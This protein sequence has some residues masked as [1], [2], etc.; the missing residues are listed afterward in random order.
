MVGSNLIEHAEAKN[1]QIYAP[2]RK[3]LN[4][5]DY[6]RLLN[7]ME[8]IKP[9]IVIHAAGRVGGIQANI[10]DPAGF[11]T[12]NLKM[13]L[14]V[15]GVSETLG[16]KKLLNLGSSC[17]YS[18]TVKNPIPEDSI[19]KGELEPTNEGYALAKIV[20]ARHCDY[21][22]RNNK[23]KNYKTVIP[24]NLYG[25]YDKYD[26]STSHMI[27]AVIRKIYEAKLTGA[28]I[29]KIWGDGTARREF[30]VASDLA[31]FI[32]FAL[33]RFSELPQYLNVGIGR[34]YSIQEYYT[35]IARVVGFGGSF[36]NDLSKPAGMQQKL[37]DNSLLKNL[38][39][40][41]KMPLQ[42]GL[43]QAFEFYKGTL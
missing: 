23:D 18:R 35:E 6:S 28:N 8:G 7:T 12:D 2:T 27:P 4:L 15:V 1:H 21:I 32:Y 42:K 5:L 39:W 19:L 29:V 20:T 14:N 10:E 30:M 36:E 37:V 38:G 41:S 34:D 31:D 43:Y 13:G 22:S 25:R 24:C 3:E 26:V 9:D 16:I 40:E 11:L 17:M 33:D